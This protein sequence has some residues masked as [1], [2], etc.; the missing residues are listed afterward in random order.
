MSTLAY[1]SFDVVEALRRIKVVGFDEVEICETHLDPRV[2]SIEEVRKV[3]DVL[4]RI[5]LRLHS[6]H[7][8][9]ADVDLASKDSFKREAS[10][11][12][13]MK[14][15]D[16]CVEL[17]CP[18]M[19]LHPNS[20]ESLKYLTRRTMKQNTIDSVKTLADYARD[21]SVN[22]ALE[23]L[24][25][26]GVKRFGSTVSDLKLIIK[27]VGSDSVGICFDTGHANMIRWEGFS[28]EKEIRR[29]GKK[30]FTLHIHDNDGS[31]DRHWPLGRGTIDWDKVFE[32][33]RRVNPDLA[34]MHEVFGDGDPDKVAKECIR[35]TLL[36]NFF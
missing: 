30:L 6:L 36:K 20:S 14:S 13:M 33:L 26:H 3:K 24:H 27:N 17:E 16:Y 8:P 32:A 31:G 22:I 15:L 12:L 9:Y 23:N 10:L 2:Y 7:A 1:K 21:L 28:P 35:N 19:V 25:E 5:G 29:A 34:L 11:N 4:G 18:I